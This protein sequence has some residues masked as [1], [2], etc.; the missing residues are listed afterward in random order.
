MTSTDDTARFGADDTQAAQYVD[1]GMAL[2]GPAARDGAVGTA[3][4]LTRGQDPV[5]LALENRELARENSQ[6]KAAAAAQ[7]IGKLVSELRFL[8]KLTPGL[9][10]A[11]AVQLLQAAYGLDKRITI[12][13]SDGLEVGL[14]EALTNLLYAIPPSWSGGYSE[15]S[16]TGP[17]ARRPSGKQ[18]AGRD[19]SATGIPAAD[20]Y[21]DYATL[22]PRL[23]AQ[24]REVARTLGLTAEEYAGI[25]G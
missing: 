25:V 20:T 3:T 16:G 8:G 5:E 15:F 10:Q 7:R 14:G 17:R 18:D 11:G 21:D 13:Q 23:S 9:E 2:A 4:P 6:L 19:A 24:E 22:P 1:G 12:N